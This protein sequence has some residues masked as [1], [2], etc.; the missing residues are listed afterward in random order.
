MG[1]KNKKN[2]KGFLM[3]ILVVV[4]FTLMLAELLIFTMLNTSY[5]NI[6]QSAAA[7]SSSINYAAMLKSSADAFASASLSKA[8]STLESYEYNSS[9]RKGNFISNTSLY[10]STL[11]INGTL[12]NVP[13]NSLAANTLLALMGNS[14]LKAYN[15]TV[16]S[17]LR[18]SPAY[19]KISE[20]KPTVFQSNPYTISV[21][22][23][24]NIS[25]GSATGV[26][27]YSMPVVAT[28]PLNGT[29][30]LFYAQQGIYRKIKFS[31]INNMTSI[32]GNAYATY[33]N[34]SAN[35]FIYGIV[36][37]VPSGVTCTSLSSNIPS[38]FQAAPFNSLLILATPNAAQITN[39]TC[40]AANNY[41]GLI[42]YSINSIS[43]P[44]TVPWLEYS[45]STNIL[46][47]LQNGEHV[48]L[49]GPGMDTLNI[50]ALRN[51]I[52]N[53]SYFAS[54][55]APSYL[56]RSD[57]N[58]L[59]QSQNGIF[60]FSNFNKDAATFSGTNYISVPS[61]S[62]ISGSTAASMSTWINTNSLA[63]NQIVLSDDWSS[64]QVLQLYIHTD[65]QVEADFG[66]G[67]WI[68]AA[69]TTANVISINKWY[70]IVA[71][72]GSGKGISIYING[73]SEPVTY[74]VG[75]ATSTGA[76]GSPATGDIASNQGNSGNFV[77]QIVNLQ[78]YNQAI[79]PQEAYNIYEEGAGGIPISNMGLVA[80][81]P[82]NGNANDYSGFGNNGA[83]TA[84][85]YLPLQNYTR[86]SIFLI[87]T[88]QT[89]PIPGILS[90]IKG[91][92]CSSSS[93]LYLSD[94]PLEMGQGYMQTAGFNGQN[95]YI[96]QTNGFS[97]M[98]NANQ[99]ATISI[100]ANPSLPNGDIVDELGQSSINNGWH[101]TWIDLANGNIYIRV[102]DLG[103]VNLGSIP[104]HSWSNI[105]MILS[106]NGVSLNYSGY[107]NGVYKNSGSGS[108][109]IPGGSSSMYYPLGSP[110][111]TNCG[112][113]GAAFNGQM[114]DYQFYNTSLSSSQIKSLYQEGIGGMPYTA[115]LVAWWP[116]NGN[117]NDYSGFG[118]NGTAY[119][120]FYPYF[121]GAYPY[122]GLSNIMN[123]ENER[124]LLN[125]VG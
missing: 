52:A 29:A 112:D 26:Y 63:N 113:G 60:T 18:P 81:Y 121:S 68:A 123:A 71:T 59:R 14:T 19:L 94:L 49:Y 119:N 9:M 40:T 38:Q 17:D 39:S 31:S 46:Q 73:T 32:I 107:I 92:T 30:D 16:L 104:L 84:V 6:E 21:S 106:Y 33:G 62:G 80:W 57:A 78:I 88:P 111:G 124:Q 66:S 69:E 98:N 89:H 50:E 55:F 48:L 93:A 3:T 85:S 103:C 51:A 86:D 64:S 96:E 27:N 101:D 22:Y 34:T 36:Y 13:A 61:I 105:A 100:W 97:F 47:A 45:S 125:L 10:L 118:N 82:L 20:T 109:S 11:I 108:R 117:A 5:N 122:N 115:N 102:W 87:S 37:Q 41:G 114:A 42:T 83:A 120:V 76:L 54:P 74:I 110:D 77:G 28:M 67:S 44:P 95:S 12:P 25:I 23:T 72:W 58:F 35:A 15:A 53:N 75:S 8:L 65:G 70:S 91:P 90:C 1:M 116:L 2:R 7:S 56:D 79:S 99:Q 43:N 24:E 4:I